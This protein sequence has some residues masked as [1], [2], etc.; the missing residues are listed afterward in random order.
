MKLPAL[1]PCLTV[2]A[3]L[4]L[5][6]VGVPGA[7][8][9]MAASAPDQYANL[10]ATLSLTGTC[11]DF[12]ELSVTGGHPDFEKTPTAGFGHY[13]NEVADTLDSEGK[14][15]FNGT[16]NAVSAQRLDTS[17]RQIMPV[18]KSYITP[19][20][21]SGSAG[22]VA[23]ASGGSLTSS[24]KFA[25][26]YRDVAGVNISK[27]VS[28]NLVRQ[29]GT[30]I[31]SF[32]DKLDSLYASRGGFFPINGELYGNSAGETKNFHFTYEL[33]T[34]F[35]YRHGAGQVFTFTGDDDV[36]VFIGG[37]LVIDLGGVHSA[38]SQTIDLD[39]MNTLTDGQ[40]YELKLF[41]AERHRTQSNMRIDTTIELHSA[42]LPTVSGLF[43]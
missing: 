32:D 26:W 25:Q 42:S 27:Q 8:A 11:R 38:V 13:V 1:K 33:A 18:N 23:T 16:G 14:P 19:K 3:L 34:N 15:V 9:H 41:F 2:T 6:S 43:D 20:T 29:A 35:T 37:K 39:T 12:K 4:V 10:P 24:A 22:T 21:K 17:N 7:V 30:N 28:I 40:T 5:A 31:Y 36:F